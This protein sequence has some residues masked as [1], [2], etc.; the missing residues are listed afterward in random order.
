MTSLTINEI[1][2]IRILYVNTDWQKR[3]HLMHD[4][5]VSDIILSSVLDASLCSVDNFGISETT[6]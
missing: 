3:P 4:D 1:I 6:L 2:K 5:S